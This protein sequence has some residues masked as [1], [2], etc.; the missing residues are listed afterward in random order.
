MFYIVIGSEL[1][2][3]K[4]NYINTIEASKQF[5]RYYNVRDNDYEMETN[6]RW[7]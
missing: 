7:R 1:S 5:L 2:T 6:Y 3:A 4:L